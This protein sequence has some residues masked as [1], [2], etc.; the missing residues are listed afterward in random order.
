MKCGVPVVAT[1]VN[2]VPE[3]V[4]SGKTGRLA[5]PGDPESLGRALAYVLDHREEAV[6]MAEAARIHVGDRF[7][8]EVL[9]QDLME[10]YELALLNAGSR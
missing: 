4:I 8:P 5:R 2:S 9:S 1:A 10:V 7:R 3:I 6:R